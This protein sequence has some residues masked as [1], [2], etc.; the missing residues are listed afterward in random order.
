MKAT[1]QT[2]TPHGTSRTVSRVVA[3]NRTITADL[4]NE[5]TAIAAALKRGADRLTIQ[6]ENKSGALADV[7]PEFIVAHAA[8]VDLLC[9]SLS[10]PQVTAREVIELMGFTWTVQ[11]NTVT[12]DT[13][14]GPAKRRA[15]HVT[16]GDGR[17]VLI[18]IASHLSTVQ[19]V[20]KYSG[21]PDVFK[22][23]ALTIERV[24]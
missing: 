18:V 15:Y 20:L 4:L 24:N 19:K 7:Y 6:R 21:F 13:K 22:H 8:P 11:V 1:I 9:E 14:P 17:T 2:Y 12:I 3:N 23:E 10:L 5:R 16:R